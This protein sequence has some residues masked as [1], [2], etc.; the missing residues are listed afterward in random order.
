MPDKNKGTHIKKK[1]KNKQFSS[2]QTLTKLHVKTKST[3]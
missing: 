2:N 3:V 1:E